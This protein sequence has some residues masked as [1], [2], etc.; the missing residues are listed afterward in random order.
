M[1]VVAAEIGGLAHFGDGVGNRLPGLAHGKRHELGHV[2]LEQLGHA[3]EQGR[4]L[5]RRHVVPHGEA[6]QRPRERRVDVRGLRLAHAADD[7]APVG[8]IL[9]GSA[10]GP[11]A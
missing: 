4:T 7:A 1:R 11:G 5:A 9:H 8:R 2:P 3:L 10:A 6:D